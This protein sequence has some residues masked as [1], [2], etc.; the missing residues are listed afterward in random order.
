MGLSLGEERMR[1]TWLTCT[2]A[3]AG[4]GGV[5]AFHAGLCD[6]ERAIPGAAHARLPVVAQTDG[7]QA[8]HRV[9]ATQHVECDLGC[10]GGVSACRV[11]EWGQGLHGRPGVAAW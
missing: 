6:V 7:F 1:G 10:G 2:G 3:G 4:G 11:W 8:G 9:V 5:R